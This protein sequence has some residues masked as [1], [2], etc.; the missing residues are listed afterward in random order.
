V[1][2]YTFYLRLFLVHLTN[3]VVGLI[4]HRVRGDWIVIMTT[5]PS[6]IGS[7]LMAAVNPT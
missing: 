7:L 5:V 4:V 1:Q 3:V 2:L 6:A